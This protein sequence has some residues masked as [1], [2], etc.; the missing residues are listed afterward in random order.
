MDKEIYL[1]KTEII[2]FKI[3]EEVSNENN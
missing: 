3:M 2:S 1:N